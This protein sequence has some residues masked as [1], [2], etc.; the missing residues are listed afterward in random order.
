MG[1]AALAHDEALA[2]ADAIED[3]ELAAKIDLRK[4]PRRCE[5]AASRY[6]IPVAPGVRR[7]CRRHEES[8]HG[9]PHP[10]PR[11]ERANGSAAVLP[12]LSR[13]RL[14]VHEKRS[15]LRD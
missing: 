13:T 8:S 12:Q 3:Q 15:E 1:P 7:D 5:P 10:A 14:S 9:V 2:F 11:S 4:D 6:A